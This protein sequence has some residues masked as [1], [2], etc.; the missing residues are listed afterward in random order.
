MRRWLVHVDCR[1][2]PDREVM[3]HWEQKIGLWFTCKIRLW[4]ILKMHPQV[5]KSAHIHLHKR[6]CVKVCKSCA[7][8]GT[9]Q[10]VS[11]TIWTCDV[12]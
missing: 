4:S 3:L 10:M 6:S 5:Y 12:L 1:G 2:M 7:W 8:S 9:L 11:R